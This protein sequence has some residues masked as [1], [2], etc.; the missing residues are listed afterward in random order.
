MER[1][2]VSFQ[3]YRDLIKRILDCTL[4]LLALIVL[5]PFIGIVALLVRIKLGS[6]V[7]FKQPRP[8]KNEKIFNLYKFRSM[9]NAVDESGMLLPDKQRLTKFGRFLRSSSIDELLELVNIIKGDMSIV[10]PRPLSIYYLPHYSDRVRKRHEVRPGL[11]GLAQINGRNNLNW[12]ERFA[13]DLKYID[14]VCFINDLKII[15][16]TVLKVVHAENVTVRGT[17]KLRDFGT[18]SII[19]EEGGKN[20]R[21]DEMRYPEIG[22]YFWI[23]ENPVEK[24]S[25][26]K[27]MDWL[28]NC[29]DAA[30][31]LSGRGAISA[32]LSDILSNRQVKKAY[33]PSYCCISM[34]EP[35]INQG[36]KVKFYE[37]DYCDGKF[38]YKID[39][40]NDC[41]VALVM[42]YFGLRRNEANEAI[43]RLKRSGAVVIEDITHSLLQVVGYS[44]ESDYVVA[45]L[46]KWFAI[47]AGGW[48][49]KRNGKL[50]VKPNVNSD[51]AVEKKIR[52][53]Q[54]K[55]AYVTGKSVEKENYLT[56][57]ATFDTDLI[58]LDRM[59]TIDSFSLGILDET[60]I[61]A[62]VASRREN[63]R[64]L[65]EG[66]K[67]LDGKVLSL[68][69]V[70]LS[71]DVPLFLPIF[72]KTEDRDALRTYLIGRGIYCPIHWS[73][74]M[75]APV[76]VRKNELSLVCDQRYGAG[77]MCQIVYCIREWYSRYMNTE[78]PVDKATDVKGDVAQ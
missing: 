12:E 36:I 54:E 47:P 53:M 32:A 46:R 48:I 19:E 11:T 13:L 45:S 66:L 4:A 67:G 41:D 42:D 77:D 31:T 49:G 7:V 51:H 61:E 74:V 56:L 59:L 23:D 18:N 68:P 71:R 69:V 14:H 33:V 72:L 16:D 65:L 62:V 26:E 63:V 35:F 37:V 22:S 17:A 15:L 50:K 38:E 29:E 60:D 70:D 24:K 5:S 64:L 44:V 28:P 20:T 58:H 6:P 10:G 34:I 21:R 78:L 57:Q 75:G 25:H 76:G 55:W 2:T 43:V 27:A 73:E 3:I 1:K 40:K 8:G 9:T 39:E 30:Y 52:G